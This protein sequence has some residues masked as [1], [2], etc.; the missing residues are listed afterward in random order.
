[1]LQ[2]KDRLDFSYLGLDQATLIT[3][4]ER[5]RTKLKLINDKIQLLRYSQ[6]DR[7]N[8]KLIQEIY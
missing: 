1:M 7:T 4:Q 3:I 2:N 8:L 6:M 5:A